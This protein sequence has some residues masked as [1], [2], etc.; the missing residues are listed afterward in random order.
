MTEI[1]LIDY[2]NLDAATRARYAGFVAAHTSLER[3]LNWGREQRP[4]LEIDSILRQ[5]EYTHDVLVPFEEAISSM[6][7][8]D[9]GP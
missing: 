4:P 2:A 6:T 1:P 9:W 8:P 3:A 5:D 7:Q